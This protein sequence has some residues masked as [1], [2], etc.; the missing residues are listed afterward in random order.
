MCCFFLGIIKTFIHIHSQWHHPFLLPRETNHLLQQEETQCKTHLQN[1]FVVGRIDF[2][3]C[4]VDAMINLWLHLS[5]E[6]FGECKVKNLDGSSESF[7]GG[8]ELF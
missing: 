6:L 7:G 1:G 8:D 4:G 2:G 3:G 5:L